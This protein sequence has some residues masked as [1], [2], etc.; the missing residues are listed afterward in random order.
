MSPVFKLFEPNSM[1]GSE[2]TMFIVFATR[3]SPWTRRFDSKM[4]SSSNVFIPL[5]VMLSD[6]KLVTLAALDVKLD[7]TSTFEASKFSILST[8]D[9]KPI[10]FDD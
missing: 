10:T 8:L 3:R 5:I 6:S 2:T 9:V 1:I 7:H 4:I